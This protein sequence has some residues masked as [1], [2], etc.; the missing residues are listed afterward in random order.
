[1]LAIQHT[2]GLC[3]S[4]WYREQEAGSAKQYTNVDPQ[5]IQLCEEYT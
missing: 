1:M 5:N 4:G 2:F 3:S